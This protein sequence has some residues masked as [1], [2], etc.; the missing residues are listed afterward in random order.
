MPRKKNM[1]ETSKRKTKERVKK[2]YKKSSVKKSAEKK[3]VEKSYSL[4]ALQAALNAMGEGQTLRQAAANFGVPKS[5]LFL[6]SKCIVPLECKKGPRTVLSTEDEAEIVSWIVFSADS[7]HPVTKSRLLDYVQKYATEK[8]I[9]TP[10]KNNRPG[11]HWYRAF[12]K[13]NP[14]LSNKIV[15]N[16]ASTRAPVTEE[17]LRDWF[18]KIRLHLEDK[19]LL[20]IEPHR[21]FNAGESTFMLTPK[22]NKVLTEEGVKA[23][24]EIVSSNEKDTSTVLFSISASGVM[25]PP[26]IL[27]DFKKTPKKSVIDKIPKGWGVVNTERGLTTSESFYSYITNVFYKW[28]KENNYV[29]P[30]ILYVDGRSSQITLPLLKFCKDHLIELIILY[31]NA[32]HII[33][34][35]DVAIFHPLKDSYK[36]V[37]QEW[38]IDNNIYNFKKQ[39][40]PPVLKMALEACDFT[41]AAITGFKTCGLYPLC[42]D[43]VNYNILSKKNKKKDVTHKFNSTNNAVQNREEI[44]EGLLKIFEQDLISPDVLASFKQAETDGVWSGDVAY[45][46]LFE[47]WLKLRK[48]CNVSDAEMIATV[49]DESCDHGM[50]DN[51]TI[52]FVEVQMPNTD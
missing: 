32:T 44:S 33:H 3:K 9:D 34:P 10:F 51:I 40:F 14:N 24:H 52:D 12:M 42:A 4:E 25:P 8:K 5:T 6:K 15:H 23:P 48:L 26:M 49:S 36:K 11:Q 35:L 43:A 22:Y 46:A 2:T 41:E 17:D 29:F 27:F 47:S 19:K 45:V 39:M 1:R 37:L 21:I 31:P 13:R 18:A 20:N 16:H 28:L 50:S 38:R 30:V 7:G